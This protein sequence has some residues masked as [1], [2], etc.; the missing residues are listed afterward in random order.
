MIETI[1]ETEAEEG[2]PKINT[3]RKSSVV[4]QLATGPKFAMPKKSGR[5]SLLDNNAAT[6]AESIDIENMNNSRP[7]TRNHSAGPG[8]KRHP[9]TIMEKLPSI[10]MAHKRKSNKPRAVSNKRGKKSK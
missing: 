2:L 5:Q 6:E 7:S 8:D 9:S 1:Q 10:K 3:E 4:Q